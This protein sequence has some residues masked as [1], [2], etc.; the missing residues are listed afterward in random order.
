MQANILSK[1]HLLPCAWLAFSSVPQNSTT[2]HNSK[3]PRDREM[4]MAEWA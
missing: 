4:F 2:P 3:T 1:L